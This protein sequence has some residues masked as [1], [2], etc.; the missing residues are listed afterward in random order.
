M[1]EDFRTDAEASERR[2]R[3]A[4]DNASGRYETERRFRIDDGWERHE[5]L[6]PIR[7]S[8]Q[9]D[10]SRR[11]ITRNESP[12][13]PFDRSINP[14]RGCEHGCIYCFARPTHAWLGL[15]PGLDFETRLFVK[16][17]APERLVEE[18]AKPGY[19]CRP[20]AF[21]TNTDP[22]QPIERERRVTR[23]LIEVLAECDHPLTIVTKS[24]LV[25][26]DLDILEPMA[27]K[28]L[29]KVALSITT[30]DRHLARVMEP[31][32]T[33]PA[34]RL[35]AVKSL[36]DAGIPTSVLFAPT[37][38]GLNDHEMEKVLE[39]AAQAGAGEAGYILLRLPLEIRELFHDW[40][41][42]HFPNRAERVIQLVRD[43]RGGRDYQAAFGRRMTGQGPYAELTGQRFRAALRRYGLD[44][45]RSE[46][47]CGL[48]R[49]PRPAREDRQMSL[50]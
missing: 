33:T 28:G 20:I 39:L 44:K 6:P 12:D 22:Y 7:T 29:V 41:R 13:V 5:E 23:R 32:A 25:L 8:V 21:G 31:R 42:E 2:G 16:P 46:L 43:T 48:F 38:P 10:K 1:I 35:E 15:S 40:L 4:L 47:D 37:I 18:L 49:P 30:L 24:N 50:L 36:S 45:R 19:R 34:R 9:P 11:V 26:R 14:Y 17:E 3:G 27:R